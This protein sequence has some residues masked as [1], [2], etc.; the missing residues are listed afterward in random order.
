[1]GKKSNNYIPA[2]RYNWLTPFYD[3]IMKLMRESTI[4][5]DLVKSVSIKKNYKLLDLGCGTA[6]LTILLKKTYPDVEIIGL[7]GDPKVLEI[8]KSK[9]KQ[10][11][12][13]IPL[14]EGMSFELPYEDNSFDLVVSSLMFHHLTHENK[15]R[16]FKE[17]LRVLR[18]DGKLYFVDFGKPHNTLMYLISL[19]MRHLEETSDNIDGLLPEMLLKVGFSKIEEIKKYSTIFGSVY[20]YQTKI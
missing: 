18:D 4:K 3:L 14:D 13:D 16:T 19:V 10:E 8:A 15:I 12:L 7:D 17:I 6:T 20:L 1:M 5:N 2:F 11:K 9:I